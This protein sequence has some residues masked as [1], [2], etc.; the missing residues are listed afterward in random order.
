MLD[1]I[2]ERDSPPDVLV[3][4]AGIIGVMTAYCLAKSGM[5]VLIMDRLAQPALGTSFANAGQIMAAHAVPWGAPIGPLRTMQWLLSRSPPFRLVPRASLRQWRW[6]VRWLRETSPS[7]FAAN[8]AAL[9]QAAVQSRRAFDAI[10]AA[11]RIEFAYRPGLLML[12]RDAAIWEHVRRSSEECCDDDRAIRCMSR[13]QVLAL[14]PAL[15]EGGADI[16]GATLDLHDGSGDCHTFATA[17]AEVCRKLGVRFRFSEEARRLVTS[18]S[19]R[20][21]KEVESVNLIT[22]V[23]SRLKVARV[24]VATGAHATELLRHLR[25]RLDIYPARGHSLTVALP[26]GASKPALAITDVAHRVVFTPLGTRLRIAGTAELAGYSR[27]PTAKEVERLASAA[28]SVF[29]HLRDAR[30]GQ[31]WVGLRPMTPSS[32]PYVQRSI[33]DNVYLNVGHGAYGWTLAAGSAQ[34]ICELVLGDRA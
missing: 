2:V 11:E 26:A 21:V 27:A 22:G 16:A 34:R 30:L 19:S 32:L 29:P 28:Q 13:Q 23:T 24:V 20:L 3:L 4:G 1:T 15:E 17:L 10:R 25:V 9:R 12:Y 14:E 18:K 5:S 31:R 6:V 7:R 8:A 33:H